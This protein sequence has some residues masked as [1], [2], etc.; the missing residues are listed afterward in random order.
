MQDSLTTHE[1]THLP[2]EHEVFGYG[3]LS[4]HGFD[5]EPYIFR[6]DLYSLGDFPYTDSYFETYRLHGN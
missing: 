4:H 3:D 5:Y 1:K 2:H 6:N